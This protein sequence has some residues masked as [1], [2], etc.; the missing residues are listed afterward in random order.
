VA[1]PA[2]LEAIEELLWREPGF[3]RDPSCKKG[4]MT[5]SAGGKLEPQIR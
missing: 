3:A 5:F 2:P 4:R 1:C